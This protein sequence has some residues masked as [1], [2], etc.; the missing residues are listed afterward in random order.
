[1]TWAARPAREA[2]LAG[3]RARLTVGRRRIITACCLWAEHLRNDGADVARPAAH[4]G[5]C[6]PLDCGR[7]SEKTRGLRQRDARRPVEREAIDAGAD[8][9]EGDRAYI[10]LRRQ[11]QAAAVAVGQRPTPLMD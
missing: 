8:G 4:E 9:G 10:V 5:E 2:R 3:R 7:A 1:M 11:G 6:H